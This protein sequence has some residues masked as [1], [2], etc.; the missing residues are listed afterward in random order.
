[1]DR[2]IIGLGNPGIKY[3]HT[4]HNI[5]WDSFDA[6][7]FASELRWSDKFKGIYAT[8]SHNGEK[9]YFLKPQTFMNLSGESV[10]PLMNFLKYRSIIY[11]SFTMSLIYLL[12]QLPL[13][14]GRTRRP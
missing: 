12:A 1:M 2:L 14:K 3:H 13:K 7:S 4:R 10:A 9:I 8:Y 11:W 5:G 6:L